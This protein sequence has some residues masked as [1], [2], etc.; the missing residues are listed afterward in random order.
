MVAVVQGRQRAARGAG[1]GPALVCGAGGGEAPEAGWGVAG[2][3]AGGSTGGSSAPAATT[4]STP[5]DQPF[6]SLHAVGAASFTPPFPDPRRPAFRT[7]S[8]QGVVEL[9]SGGGQSWM[10]AHLFVSDHP[11]Y[12]R[13]DLE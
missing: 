13:T 4:E 11:Y 8:R 10:R 3:V 7:L 2:A 9:S 6:Y 1:L 5:A 12:T